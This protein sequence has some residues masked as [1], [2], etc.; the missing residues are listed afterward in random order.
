M[1]QFD[2]ETLLDLIVNAVPLAIMLFFVVLFAVSNPF[3]WDPVTTTLQFSIVIVTFVA[4]AVL[5]YYSGKAIQESE[6]ALESA[7]EAYAEPQA[8]AADAETSDEFDAAD[9]GDVADDGD[10]TNG[11]GAD[12]TPAI[13]GAGDGTDAE[14]D[15]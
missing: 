7:P 9:F 15:A 8:A 5:T 1:F 3:G 10:R 13:A 6:E 14:D 12:A 11:E 2:E 4:L